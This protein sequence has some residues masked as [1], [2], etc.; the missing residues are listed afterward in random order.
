MK[1]GQRFFFAKQHDFAMDRSTVI[2]LIAVIYNS[3]F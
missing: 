3:Y 1:G 2:S